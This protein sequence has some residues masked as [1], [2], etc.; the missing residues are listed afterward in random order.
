MNLKKGLCFSMLTLFLVSLLCIG[1]YHADNKYTHKSLQPI[2]GILFYEDGLSYLTRQWVV[3]PDVLLTPADVDTYEGYRYYEDIG[4]AGK[5]ESGSKTY[6]LTL[7]LPEETKEYALE[8]PEIFSACKLYLNDRLLLQLGNPAPESY[9]EGLSSPIATF[10]AEGKTELLL[11][12]SDFSGINC[13][14]TYPPAFGSPADVLSARETRLF[15]HR[16]LVLLALLGAVLSLTFGLK[17]KQKN[18]ILTCLLCLCLT[19]VTGYPLYHGMLT[20]AVQP[21]YTIEP[22]CY[23]AMLLLALLLQ[24]SIYGLQPKQRLLFSIPCIIGF[25][26]TLVSFGGASILPKGTAHVFSLLSAGLKYYTALSLLALSLWALLKNKAH[27]ILLLCS[28]TALATCLFW[29]RFLPL[30]EPIYGGWFGEIG[31]GLFVFSLAA[32]LWLDA[33]DAYKFRLTYEASLQQMEQRLALQKEHYQQLSH[34]IHLARE[35]GHDL[36][37]HMRIMR[38][39]AEQKDWVRLDTYLQNYETHTQKRQL[40]LWSEH[41]VADAVLQHYVNTA[42]TVHCIYDVSMNI[43]PD[44]PFPDE[45][46]C[47]ILSNL[48]ENAIDAVSSQASGIKRIYLRGE[49]TSHHLG[50]VI[51]NTY[52]GTIQTKNGIFL[53][54]KHKGCGLGL[55][56][57]LTIVERHNGLA[58]FSTENGIFHTSLLIPFSSE[59]K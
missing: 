6:H 23:Y 3:Y 45:D 41:P 40:K 50:I 57:V 54:T 8:L 19:V 32:A 56:S 34:Q 4:E 10:S 37:H 59:N 25:G 47:I 1:L 13:G 18:G 22:S 52:D 20:T 9:Q 2:N 38:S 14:L 31:G 49:M 55:Q 42:E 35:A 7:M 12:V 39:F 30:Y 28:T 51:D 46:L 36:R 29:D 58:D 15:I 33:V 5:N 53:S 27:S 11:A 43:P 48:L 26:A 21:W 44:L 17:G 24:C 16:S